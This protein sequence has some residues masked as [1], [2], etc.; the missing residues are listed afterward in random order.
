MKGGVTHQRP[1]LRRPSAARHVARAIKIGGGPPQSRTLP[2]LALPLAAP[3]V[4]AGTHLI[5]RE[6]ARC[7]KLGVGARH[8]E[9]EYP[10]GS[11]TDEQRS[12][13]GK[14]R[15]PSGLCSAGPLAALLLSHRA[16]L[17]AA[18]TVKSEFLEAHSVTFRNTSPA[19]RL[20]LL[21]NSPVGTEH[22]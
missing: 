8:E 9:R 6:R 20:F 14:D 4:I 11:S 10:Q 12:A 13:S 5:N 21:P 3:K 17:C 16:L 7:Q 1:G 18:R 19:Q 2:R 22:E 15:Q